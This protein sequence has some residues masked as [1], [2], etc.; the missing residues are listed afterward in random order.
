MWIIFFI[1]GVI[2]GCAIAILRPKKKSC[3]KLRVV[4]SDDQV[5]PYIFLELSTGIENILDQKD[6]LLQVD[7]EAYTSHK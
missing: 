1:A 3:G 6:I 2:V 7:R 4:Y 5:N